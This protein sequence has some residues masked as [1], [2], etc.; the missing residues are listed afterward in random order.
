V[1]DFAREL[2]VDPEK[3][4]LADVD[5]SSRGG[6]QKSQ[7]A[8][9]Q[10]AHLGQLQALQDR[11]YAQGRYALLVVL[12]AM[13]AGGKDGTIKHVMSGLNPQ[14]CEVHSF[15]APSAEELDHDYLWRAHLRVPGRGRIGIFNR[16]HYEEVL[17][18]RVHPELLAAQRLP[19]DSAKDQHF[20]E[21]RFEDIVWFERYLHRNGT[22]VVKFF[23]HVS[24]DEQRRRF[25]K[26]IEDPDKNWKVARADVEER[27]HWDAY[28]RAYEQMIRATSTDEV[29]W[30][31]IPA[32]HKWFA[33]TAVGAIVVHALKE[34]DPRYPA[35]AG[36][37]RQELER[38]AKQLEREG[39]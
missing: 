2:R 5:P 35:V 13:D 25:L 19:P 14:G 9:L 3:F 1:I 39:G 21:H 33:H 26:R 7:G 24:R 23:L 29:P 17:I 20:W 11:L 16:S 34:I 15:K 10:K 22:R 12:Q 28:Q 27:A 36:K 6:L 31:V 30:Y 32:D 38:L 4:S 8:E 37:Q 18:V